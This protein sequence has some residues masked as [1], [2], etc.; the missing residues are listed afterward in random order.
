MLALGKELV[1]L[2]RCGLHGGDSPTT[3]RMHRRNSEVEVFL[4]LYE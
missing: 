1:V 3:L 4:A 2:S